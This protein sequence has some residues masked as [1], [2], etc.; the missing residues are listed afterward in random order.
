VPLAEILK[1]VQYDR[2][3]DTR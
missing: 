2:Q 1:A 3:V